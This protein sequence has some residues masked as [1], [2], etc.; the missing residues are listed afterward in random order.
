MRALSNVSLPHVAQANE[1]N[2]ASAE[3]SNESRLNQNFRIIQG[4][5][6]E[7]ELEQD[8]IK[9]RLDSIEN[10]P[11]GTEIDSVFDSVNW[12]VVK[13]NTGD[14]FATEK[15][16]TIILNTST[17][18]GG[19]FYGDTSVML[20]EGIAEIATV[21]VTVECDSDPVFAVIKNYNTSA[22]D[23]RIVSTTSGIHTFILYVTIT[24]KV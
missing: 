5:I 11:V 4:T 24:G 13:M 8:N 1:H 10:A 22:V 7:M 9:S 6:A 16:D 17:A 14:M 12:R 2:R 19:M 23:V 20:P 18:S 21:Q 3:R 15:T